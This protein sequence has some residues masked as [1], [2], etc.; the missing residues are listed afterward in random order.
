V[1]PGLDAASVD[2]VALKI[3]GEAHAVAAAVEAV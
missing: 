2:C 1:L 3:A